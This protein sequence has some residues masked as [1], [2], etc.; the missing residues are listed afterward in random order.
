MCMVPLLWCDY[1]EVIAAYA[2]MLKGL[3]TLSKKELYSDCRIT[4]MLTL[5]VL[6]L[7]TA[8]WL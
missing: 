4:A 1:H 3:R 5:Y 8:V 2:C 7:T 6:F